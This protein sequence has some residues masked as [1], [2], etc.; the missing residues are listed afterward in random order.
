[1]SVHALKHLSALETLAISRISVVYF[2]LQK[3]LMYVATSCALPTCVLT[4][5]VLTNA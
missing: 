2:S 3:A 5:E 1:M 4:N